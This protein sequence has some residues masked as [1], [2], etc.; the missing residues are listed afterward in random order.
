MS[1]PASTGRRE[2]NK[3]R[4]RRRLLDAARQLFAERGVPG[5]TVEDIAE[6]AEVSR[7]TLFNYFPGKG[8][9]V[10]ALHDCHMEM[11][12]R[13]VDELLSH[14]LTTEE[15]LV[16]VFA[17][18]A[19]ETRE[20]PGYLRALT[21]ELE[22]DMATAELSDARTQRPDDELVRILQAGATRGEVRTDHPLRFLGGMVGAMYLSTVRHWRYNPDDDVS[23]MFDRAARFAAESIGPGRMPDTTSR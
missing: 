21:A 11:L 5:T 1:E 7:A 22:K 2:Q 13:L 8:A 12:A 17:D 15:R 18:F 4:T 20:P 19:R 10:T 3:R 16:A 9:L 6:L 23:E 14:D